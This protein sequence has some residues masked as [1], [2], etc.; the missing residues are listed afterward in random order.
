MIDY[1]ELQT[2][3][4]KA[5]YWTRVVMIALGAMLFLLVATS[6]ASYDCVEEMELRERYS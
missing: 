3:E 2:Q 5:T 4:T 1:R 6:C